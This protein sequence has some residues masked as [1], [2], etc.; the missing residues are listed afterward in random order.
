MAGQERH[1]INRDGV[2]FYLCPPEC[3]NIKAAGATKGMI[4]ADNDNRGVPWDL[5]NQKAIAEGYPG[6]QGYCNQLQFR[7]RATRGICHLD[8]QP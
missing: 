3:P 4:S 7:P 5:I 1:P 6:G 8:V 2:I